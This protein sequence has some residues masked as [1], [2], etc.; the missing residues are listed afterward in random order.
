MTKIIHFYIRSCHKVMAMNTQTRMEDTKQKS[1]MYVM[2]I[3]VSDSR[4]FLGCVEVSGGKG[5]VSKTGCS[6][7]TFPRSCKFYGVYP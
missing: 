5:I 7:C 6:T 4:T 1:I 3:Y 2:S